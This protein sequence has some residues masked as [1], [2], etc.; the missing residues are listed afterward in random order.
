MIVILAARADLYW[1]ANEKKKRTIESPNISRLAYD[2]QILLGRPPTCLVS[3]FFCLLCGVFALT[4]PP[5]EPGHAGEVLAEV[6][7]SREAEATAIAQLH[8]ESAALA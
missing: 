4:P 2:L 6:F 7:G 3:V 5:P 8:R 1:G